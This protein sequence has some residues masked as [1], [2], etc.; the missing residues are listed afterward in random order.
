MQ[1]DDALYGIFF[2][3]RALAPR[4]I[5]IR[6]A[7]HLSM[8]I[9]AMSKFFGS[10]Q[11]GRIWALVTGGVLLVTAIVVGRAAFLGTRA[12]VPT[13]SYVALYELRP[14]SF[15]SSTPL[16]IPVRVAFGIRNEGAVAR[17]EHVTGTLASVATTTTVFR[18][19]VTLPAGAARTFDLPFL[20]DPAHG[21]STL[22]V[23]LTPADQKILLHLP[24]P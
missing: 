21:S 6:R 22:T 11:N 19:D 7:D 1:H 12:P 24:P 13:A 14:L 20:Y 16:G 2:C 10:N 4:G 3:M 17:T 23:A 18:T 5:T 9:R 8:A 15:G